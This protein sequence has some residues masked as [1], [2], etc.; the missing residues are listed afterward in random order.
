MSVELPAS[1]PSPAL[2]QTPPDDDLVIKHENEPYDLLGV[3]FGPT[4]IALAVAFA[5][6]RPGKRALFIDARETFAWH[7]ALLLPASRMQIS[8]LKDLATFRN[9]QSSFSFVSYLH[10]FG[11]DRLAS[12]S[13]LGSWTPSRT[14]WAS[15]L[16]W[17][18]KRLES[19]V[20]WSSKVVSVQPT[21]DAGDSLVEITVRDFARQTTR[22][23]YARNL[24]LAPGATPFIPKLFGD[25]L[26]AFPE[27]AHTSAYL[28]TLE[29][30]KLNA[31]T[32]SG[33]VAVVGGGQSS[34]EV[35]HDL[36]SRFPNAK[37]DMFYRASALVPADDSPFVNAR[38]FD[39][40]RTEE[41][42]GLQTQERSARLAEFR[43]ANYACVAPELIESMYK[44]LYLQRLH[45][46]EPQ[47]RIVPNTEVLS[48]ERGEDGVG[49][50]LTIGST[51]S[52]GGA[53]TTGE[54][55]AVFLGTG[56]HRPS[57]S[58]SF[59]AGLASEY[60]AL[61]AFLSGAA[62]ALEVGRDYALEGSS[63]RGGRVF[64]LG[65]SE[66]THGLSE[67]L[68]SVGA[69]RAGEVVAALQLPAAAAV[70][71]VSTPV[72]SKTERGRSAHVHVGTLTPDSERS[73]ERD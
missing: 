57:S 42:F 49:V 38:A 37:V 11:V 23:V 25:V 31:A 40:A 20:W 43:R 4:H 18:A 8:F 70:A 26:P 50:R 44:L 15:Y 17:A 10:S 69:V 51:L 1:S 13:N 52:T 68:L 56:Y 45:P 73:P 63:E 22:V 41:F 34:A 61:G 5:E 36:I 48:V 54:Y 29:R 60:P 72:A 53:P 7:P 46:G 2:L 62:P 32:F 35:F 6:E 55:A 59:L 47:H 39:P 33:R 66:T 64:V 3:G 30:L 67:T 21:T 9:P 19:N 24:S 16:A 58:L 14:E 65:F 27:I 28:S 71:E 12:F